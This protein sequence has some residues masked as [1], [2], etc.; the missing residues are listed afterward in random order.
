MTYLIF[1]FGTLKCGFQL[2]DRGLGE[3]VCL[4][5]FKT[6][7][8]FPLVIAGRWFAPMLLHEPGKGERVHGELYEIEHSGLSR[9]DELESVGRP[10]NFRYRIVVEGIDRPE[11]HFAYAFFKSAE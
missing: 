8:R 2:H 1:V 3:S 7:E 9:L 10:D 4:G 11:I 6:V 5:A